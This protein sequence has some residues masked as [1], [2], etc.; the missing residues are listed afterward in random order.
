MIPIQSIRS[1]R[2]ELVPATLGHVEAEIESPEALGQ[3]LSATVPAS[4][5]PGEY[6]R[7]AMEFFRARISEDPASVGWYGWYAVRRL[8][9]GRSVVIGAAG[10]LGPPSSDGTVE[11]GC[12]IA[13]EFQAQGYATE[14]VRALVTRAWSIPGVSRVIAH[15]QPKNV[16]SIKVL[17]RCGFRPVGSG[18]EP[19]AVEYAT[20][21]ST[22]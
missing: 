8:E 13:P 4:W 10:Y 9:R 12:S 7:S 20:L 1:A 18:G 21:R 15:A 2:L 5:P 14:I 6:N 22:T 17:E 11:V 19:G 16:G 3:L